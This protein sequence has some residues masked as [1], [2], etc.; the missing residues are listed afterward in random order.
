MIYFIRISFSLYR[1]YDLVF[2][3]EL[4][5]QLLHLVGKQLLALIQ[6]FILG[7]HLF[8]VYQDCCLTYI[9]GYCSI[10]ECDCRK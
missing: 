9:I 1:S 6:P 2:V 3:G 8:R 7:F 4:R 5:F 10:A